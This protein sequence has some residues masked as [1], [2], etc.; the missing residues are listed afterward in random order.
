MENA[1][2]DETKETSAMNIPVGKE[3]MKKR[4]T[5]WFAE[6]QCEALLLSALCVVLS[7]PQGPNGD[8]I[9][10]DL[11]F[12]FIAVSTLFLATGFLLTTAI[13]SAFWRGESRWLYSAFAAA[14]FSVLLQILFYVTDPEDKHER[15]R[16]WIFGTC[17]VF[18]CSL[19]GGYILRW[20]THAGGDLTDE[21]RAPR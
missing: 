13:V 5:V 21:H 12:G 20:W 16:Y 9:F 14:L 17:I 19:V 8:G 6:T 7:L 3:L 1:P 18:G 15:L 10:R 11:V 2:L 4:I